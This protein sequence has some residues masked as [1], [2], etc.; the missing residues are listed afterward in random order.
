MSNFDAKSLAA[1]FL[2]KKVLVIGDIMV[3][4]YITGS[5]K[6]ISPEAPVPV[7]DFKEK[8]RQAGGACNV[9]H[10][11]RGLGA[12]VIMAGVANKDESGEWLLSH[13]KEQGI[14][15][16]GIVAEAM[17]PT[18]TKTRYATKGQQ[19]LR[20]DSEKTD[21]ILTETKEKL[22]ALLEAKLSEGLDAVVLS[23]YRKGVFEDES[24]VRRI[25]SMCE[26]NDTFVGID[27]K[28]RNIAAFKGAS[29]VKPNNLELEDAVNIKITD[30]ESL[31]EAGK[32]YLEKSGARALVVTRGAKGISLF[33]PDKMRKDFAARDVQVY[34]VCGAGDTV[35]STI[36]MGMISSL[37]IDDA[38]VL[39]NLAAGVV[40]SKVGTVAITADELMDA[41]RQ[42]GQS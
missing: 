7:L 21:G 37:S 31:N 42:P 32:R 9:A 33:M 38:I 10:N 41:A 14:S 35:I 26:E 16:E 17:R 13:L 20:V 11:I 22:F 12:N 28:S 27:S 34:D 29:V 25:I 3:D 23:D 5:V 6:R 2:D 36:T 4:E 40:I 15:A 18:T 1:A 8:S 19:L 39:A 30:E 24:F